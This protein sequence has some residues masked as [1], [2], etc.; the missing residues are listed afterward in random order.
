MNTSDLS[1]IGTYSQ[2]HLANLY[3]IFFNKKTKALEQKTTVYF[4]HCEDK[5]ALRRICAGTHPDYET[6]NKPGTSGDE[7]VNKAEF[8]SYWGWSENKGKL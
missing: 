1:N 5:D 4:R 8:D 6:R 3:Q 7:I 2:F